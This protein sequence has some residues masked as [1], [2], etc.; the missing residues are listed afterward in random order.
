MDF[1]TNNKINILI[2][3]HYGMYQHLTLTVRFTTTADGILI[4]FFFFLYYSEKI[5]LDNSHEMQSPIFSE[6]IIKTNLECHLLQ[7]CLAMI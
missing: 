4:F 2:C 3:F 5:R 6:N 7:F 1:T